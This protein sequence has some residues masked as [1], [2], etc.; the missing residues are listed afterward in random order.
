MRLEFNDDHFPFATEV[1]VRWA[2][3]DAAQIAY[4]G[5][6]LTWLEVARV[7]YFRAQAAASLRVSIDDPI[8]QDRLLGVYPLTFALASAILDWR[9]PV[10]VDSRVRIAV[11]VRRIGR[12]SI[13]H[14]YLL[15]RCADNIVVA[16]AQTTIVQIDEQSLCSRPIPDPLR[17]DLHAFKEALQNVTPQHFSS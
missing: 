17:T 13:D 5:S 15:T 7:E 1:R 8:V 10:R 12:C 2:D 16:L 3:T 14:D 6:Y 4:N 11:R 9:A